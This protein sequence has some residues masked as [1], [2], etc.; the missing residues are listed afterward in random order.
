MATH[1][2]RTIP[3]PI[4][5]RLGL[6]PCRTR[7]EQAGAASLLMAALI[8]SSLL[9]GPL[10]PVALTGTDGPLGP[11]LGAGIV[12]AEFQ[13]SDLDPFEDATAAINEAGQTVFMGTISGPGIDS[14]NNRGIW[15][16][17]DG[18]LEL[19]ARTGDPAPGTEPGVVFAGFFRQPN[20]SDSG[21]VAF[22]GIVSGP[23]VTNTNNDGAWIDGSG[24]LRLLLRE[25]T[26]P[27][28]SGTGFYGNPNNPDVMWFGVQDILL[29]AGGHVAVGLFVTDPPPDPTTGSVTHGTY[30]DQTGTLREVMRSGTPVPG[31]EPREFATAARTTFSD[32]GAI[33]LWS[34][35]T[36]PFPQ[37]E[38]VWTNRGGSMLPVAKSGDP[39]P[40]TVGQFS[41]LW[42]ATP[43]SNA[44][45]RVA[46]LAGLTTGDFDYGIFSEG[47][48]GVVQP[49]AFTGA[50]APG[51][52]GG[53]GDVF[54]SFENP[55]LSDNGTTAFT[56]TINQF[57]NNRGVWSNRD[58]TLGLIALAGQPVPGATGSFTDFMGLA[59]NASGQVSF[60][61]T[62]SAGKALCVQD[63][64]GTLGTVASTFTTIDLFG[65]GSDARLLTDI[66]AVREVFVSDP[67]SASTSD[68]RRIHFNDAGDV[69]FRVAFADA[70]QGILTTAPAQ[71]PSCPADIDGDGDADVADFF[72]FVVAFAAGDPAADINGDGSIDV[73]DFFAFVAAFAAGCP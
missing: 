41:T 7:F 65:D 6:A 54:F 53:P 61:A 26:T 14:T 9:G 13:V 50:L 56:G 35:T 15:V 43:D 38:G 17:R 1:Q 11:G 49:I 52:A 42:G 73:G 22:R 8:S 40:G 12:F 33:A 4:C 32:S 3:W 30:S 71:G 19:V 66:V 55:A 16:E 72:A 25:N 60:F 2:L 29:N 34:I 67:Q 20:I 36:T 68:G 24:S 23:G 64:A 31:L 28:P 5:C 10:R 21:A 57:S 18:G 47:L 27:L 58:G 44:S 37:F 63:P 46:F 39:A 45:D 70:S 48:F 51:T 69:S 59:I 62:T